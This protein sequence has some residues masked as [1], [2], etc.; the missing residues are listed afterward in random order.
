M[1]PELTDL[2]G[3]EIARLQ[4]HEDSF[5]EAART[6]WRPGEGVFAARDWF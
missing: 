5:R 3:P 2:D 4:V 6:V 1:N